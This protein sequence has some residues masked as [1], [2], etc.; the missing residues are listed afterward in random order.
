M[1]IEIKCGYCGGTFK[2]EDYRSTHINPGGRP[3]I[4]GQIFV[5]QKQADD[6]IKNHPCKEEELKES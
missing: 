6:W 4:N 2:V 5:V 3:D 1:I